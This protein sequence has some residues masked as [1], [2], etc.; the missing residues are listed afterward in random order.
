VI[1][2]PVATG[3]GGQASVTVIRGIVVMVQ[4]ADMALVTVLP[5]HLSLPLAV[6]VSVTEQ[7]FSGA[8]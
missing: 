5:V 7:A 2:L 1:K 8:V 4:V 6:N 3:V